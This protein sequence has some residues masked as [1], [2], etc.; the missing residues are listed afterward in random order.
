[1]KKLVKTIFRNT[2]FWYQWDDKYIGQ[3]IALGKYEPYL[4]KLILEKIGP[5]SVIVDV[6]ANIGY[7][8]LLAG[9]TAKKVYAIEPEE[10]NFSILKKNTQSNGLK[11]IELIKAG[12]GR[13][14]GKVT[15]KRSKINPGAHKVEMEGGEITM[16][17]LDD[18]I[19]EKVDVIKIDV[20]GMEA[21]VIRGAKNLIEKWR[22]IIFLEYG[23]NGR[24]KEMIKFLRQVYGSIYWIDEYGQTYRKIN[25]GKLDRV[26]GNLMVKKGRG[27]E[28]EQVK[29]IRIKKWIKRWI[30]K[31]PLT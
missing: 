22:P 31:Y 11:N 5:G 2:V 20:E 16:I 9:K 8:S 21:N 4:S 27:W 17:K 29:N 24:D 18:L 6:G 10:L 14:Q 7:Y 19:K 12:A 3:R 23:I 26:E 28:W 1:M 13:R 15:I 30:K 25:D